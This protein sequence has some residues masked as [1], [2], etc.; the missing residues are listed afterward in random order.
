[1]C[2]LFDLYS[3]ALARHLLKFEAIYPTSALVLGYVRNEPIYSRECVHNVSSC[4]V[5]V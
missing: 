4:I 1:M 5:S 3:Y 2:S